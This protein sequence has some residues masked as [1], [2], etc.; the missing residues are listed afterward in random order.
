MNA[1]PF[2]YWSFSVDG[3]RELLRANGL[4][5]LD[6]HRDEGE[7]IYYLARNDTRSNRDALEEQKG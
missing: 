2:H 3:Y 4:T 5:L 1:V 7:N 6:V